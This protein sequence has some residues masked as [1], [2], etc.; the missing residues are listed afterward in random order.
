MGLLHV[1]NE[2]GQVRQGLSIIMSTHSDLSTHHLVRAEP[3][4]ILDT[5][6]WHGPALTVI[7]VLQNKHGS[8]YKISSEVQVK[9][10]QKYK[11]TVYGTG[12]I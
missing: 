3:G 4:Q 2:A 11:E 10:N 9:E 12:R 1:D 8:W 5:Q 7:S 6:V